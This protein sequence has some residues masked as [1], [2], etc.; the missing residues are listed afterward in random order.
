MHGPKQSC[1]A[2]DRKRHP[3]VT[4]YNVVACLH[5][6]QRQTASAWLG[7]TGCRAL[8]SI[9]KS[10]LIATFIRMV[11]QSKLAISCLDIF[12]GGM[13]FDTQ[14]LVRVLPCWC[15]CRLK[16]EDEQQEEMQQ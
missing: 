11:L 9:Y 3:V 16:Q 8:Q 2:S 15:S 4:T 7:Q 5:I 12:V 13:K 6:S 10:G 14:K 1:H